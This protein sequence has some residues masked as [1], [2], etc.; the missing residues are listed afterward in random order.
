MQNCFT[1]HHASAELKYLLKFKLT[2]LP[3]VCPDRK[4]GQ[5][6]HLQLSQAAVSVLLIQAV[7]QSYAKLN[8]NRVHRVGKAGV[9]EISYQCTLFAYF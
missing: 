5:G 4:H 3:S 9:W 2:F 1:S 7:S 6:Q 8:N